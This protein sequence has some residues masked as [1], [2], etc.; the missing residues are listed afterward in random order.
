MTDWETIEADLMKIFE[1][2]P[3]KVIYEP[4]Y[5]GELYV[6]SQDHKKSIEKAISYLKG[7]YAIKH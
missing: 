7:I 5:E 1:D 4:E 6:V 2:V 3:H